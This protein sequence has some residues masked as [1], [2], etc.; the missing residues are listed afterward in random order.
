[1]VTSVVRTSSI[2]LSRVVNVGDQTV[3]LD[4]LGAWITQCTADTTRLV[5]LSDDDL[6]KHYTV[7]LVVRMFLF[8]HL[9]PSGE[10]VDPVVEELINQLQSCLD[11][12]YDEAARRGWEPKALR[13][14]ARQVLS[15][16][17]G[18]VVDAVAIF[19]AG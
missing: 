11:N 1:M 19:R 9:P 13:E 18:A 17:K 7:T 8:S 14:T 15:P 5:E 2:A 4:E 16:A 6:R 12:V 10:P 3:G